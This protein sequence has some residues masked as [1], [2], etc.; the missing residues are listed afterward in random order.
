MPAA[1]DGAPLPSFLQYARG[2]VL[3]V[4]LSAVLA[5]ARYRPGFYPGELTLFTAA[6]QEPGL[7]SLETIWG[8]HAHV[9]SVV[10][11]AGAH[12]TMLSASN[13]E[14]VAATVTRLLPAS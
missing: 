10:E 6:E 11:T 4:G 14:S 7:P 3:N 5:S 8:K 9:L 1:S 13:A 2:R 12:S